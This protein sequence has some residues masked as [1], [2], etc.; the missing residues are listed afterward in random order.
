MSA[1][2]QLDGLTPLR[3]LSGQAGPSFDRL[4]AGSLYLNRWRGG[5]GAEGCGSSGRPRALGRRAAAAKDLQL[6]QRLAG[7]A[8]IANDRIKLI[9]LDPERIAA[10]R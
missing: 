3:L 10:E 4:R 5:G 8:Q 1:G 7:G 6:A 9:G 2:G